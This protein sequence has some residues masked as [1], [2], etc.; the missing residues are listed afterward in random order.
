[1]S[2]D[3]QPTGINVYGYAVAWVPSGATAWQIEPSDEYRN[4]PTHYPALAE[5]RDRVAFLKQR[6]FKALAMALLVLPDDSPAGFEANRIQ[7]D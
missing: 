2:K 4:L 6:G 5:T 3:L 1:M 7:Q